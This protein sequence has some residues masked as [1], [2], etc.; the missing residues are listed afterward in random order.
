MVSEN[1]KTKLEKFQK[2]IYII[3]QKIKHMH[4]K[5]QV[6]DPKLKNQKK[7]FLRCLMCDSRSLSISTQNR[8]KD[9]MMECQYCKRMFIK[10]VVIRLHGYENKM[11]IGYDY[12]FVLNSFHYT[13]YKIMF[14]KKRDRQ[15]D[16]L[17]NIKQL[18]NGLICVYNA[19]VHI[20]IYEEYIELFIKEE[21]F[22]EMATIIKNHEGEDNIVTF[23]NSNMDFINYVTKKI[24]TLEVNLDNV[25][26][27]YFWESIYYGRISLEKLFQMFQKKHN[28]IML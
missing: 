28:D 26:Y 5:L 23:P 3:K 15:L 7:E 12:Q 9:I 11:S 14:I 27:V 17:Y 6:L 1:Y 16:E 4:Y 21:Y 22:L 24:K 18:H 10:D 2:C 13:R 25:E 8:Y 19:I 20:S